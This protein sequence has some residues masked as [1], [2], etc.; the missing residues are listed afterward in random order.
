MPFSSG[1]SAA[2]IW[3]SALAQL[4]LRVARLNYETWLRNT[5]GLRFDGTTLVV[6][7][8]N[9][10]ARDWL[11]KRMQP[12]ILQA[13]AAAA[14]PGLKVAFEVVATTDPQEPGPMQPSLI[15]ELTPPLNPRF[16]FE[17]FL[18]SDSNELAY[19]AAKALASGEHTCYSP[20][21]IT[22]PGGNGKTHL[23]HAI[24]HEAA[25]Q[26]KR[27]LLVSADQF[28][29]EF[30]NAVRTKATA[31]FR[32][33]YR[34]VDLLL[35]DDVHLLLG[36]RVTTAE[37]YQMVAGLHDEGRLV[38]VAGD[39]SAMNGEGARFQSELRWGLVAT[40]N[41][42]SAE[43]RARFVDLK[44]RAQGIHLPDEVLHY[45]AL[46]VRSSIR[47]LEG[48][49]N[50]V[51]ARARI[52]QE[53]ITIDLAARALQPIS[54]TPPNQQQVQ[55][56]DLLQAVCRHL[57]LDEADL[58]GASRERAVTYARHVAMYLLRRDGGMTYTAIARLLDK[59]DHST[60]V[61]A[62]NQIENDLAVSP[63]V[64]ADIDS[65]RASLRDLPQ[66]I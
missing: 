39:L 50:R 40:I 57:A 63:L 56:T 60:V 52:S 15:P 29:N 32:A 37:F 61:H 31:V 25:R 38:V 8:P 1:Y 10:L 49:V 11:A 16:R 3:E 2:Q 48:A 54:S 12:M 22:G 26:R 58:R 51:A 53:P 35:V 45:I 19:S 4:S 30:T 59:K 14:G 20:L 34:E 27:F 43:E 13:L 36:K 62:C 6:G 33:R 55:P 7:T 24:A 41:P 28:L 64:R 9:D 66:A 47:E 21:F 44:A 42:A 18:T 17:T 65:I 46:R 5:V 23:L